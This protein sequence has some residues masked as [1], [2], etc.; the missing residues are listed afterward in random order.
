[1][2]SAK[3]LPSLP[4]AQERQS[5]SYIRRSL[6]AFSDQAGN[7]LL[8]A[9]IGAGLLMALTPQSWLLHDPTMVKLT[10]RLRP[11]EWSWQPDA[12]PLGSDVLGRDVFSRTVYA[13][14]W[15]YLVGVTAALISTI[16]GTVMGL[17]AGYYRGRVDTV[18]SRLIDMQLAFPAVLIAVSVLAV[19]GPNLLNTILV[20]GLI[21]WAYSARLIRSSTLSV[22]QSDF[23]DAARVIGAPNFR[24]I[25]RHIVPNIL[26]SIFVLTTF[27][28][29][30]LILAESSLSFLG[31]GVAP[32]AATW[33]GMIGGGRDYMYV[34]W[35]ITAVPGV[36][37]TITILAVNMLGDG[38]RDAFDPRQTRG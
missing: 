33:G 36:M 27:S 30:R 38:L 21:D 28:I 14:R 24:I 31:L 15:T 7:W 35:W 11:P 1:M 8:L 10:D 6:R 23:I 22:V 34:A 3:R 19:A 29:A 37:I 20:L 16:L 9:V 12:Y 5:A 17:L 32:P 4:L 25:F 2:S 13:A 18:L 26:S